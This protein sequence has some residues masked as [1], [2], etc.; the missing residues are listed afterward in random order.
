MTKRG[1]FG[2]ANFWKSSK[3]CARTW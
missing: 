3:Y 1:K 2:K